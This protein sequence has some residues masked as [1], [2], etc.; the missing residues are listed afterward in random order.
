MAWLFSRRRRYDELSDSIREHLEEKIADLTDRGMTRKQA[1][2]AARREFGNVTLI[3][4]RSREVWQWPAIEVMLPDLKLAFRRLRKSPGFTTTALLLLAIGIGASTAIFTVIDGV[5]LRPLP[6]PHSEQLVALRHTAPGINIPDLNMATSLYLTYSEESRVFQ[7]VAMWTPDSWTATSADR[8]EQ[9]PGLSVTHDFLA[10]LGVQPQLGRGFTMADETPDS[11]RTVMVSDSYWK[12]RLGGARDVV[13]RRILLNSNAYTVIGVLPPSFEFMD[14]KI[15]LVAPIRFKRS[16]VRLI[17]FCCDGIAR[18]KPAGTL[19]QA[20]ADVARMLPIAARKF[21]MNPGW[22]PTAFADA[23]IA[24]RLRLLK[25]TLV[26]DIGKMLWVLMGTVSIVLLIA[27]ANVANLFLVRADGRR[28][29]LAIRAAL[30]AKMGRLVRELLLE[31][32]LLG[33]AGGALGMAFAYFALRLLVSSDMTNLPRV[34]GI[35]MHP[36][37]FV[38]TSSVSLLAGLLLGLIPAIQYGHPKVSIS[39]RGEGRSLT[40][41]KERQRT[42]SFLIT[43]QVALALI[44]LVGSGLMI[45]TFRALHHV[46]PGFSNAEQL[47]TLNIGIPDTQIKDPEQ[48]VR[49]EEA[50]VRNI[51]AISGVSQVAAISDLPLAGGE[52]DPIYAEDHQGRDSSLPSVRR[53][54]YVSPGYF[55]T[56]DSR[57]V[58]GRDLTWSEVYNRTPV[59]L[60]SENLARELWGDPRAAMG[61]RVRVKQKDY[62]REVIGV[63]ADL[64]DDGIDQKAPAIVYWPLLLKY[65]DENDNV[66]RSPMFIARTPRAGSIALR[67]DIQRAVAGVNASLAISEVSTLQSVYDRSL[68]RSSVVLALLAIAGAMSLLLGVVGIYAVISYSVSQRRREIGIRLAL[69]AQKPA[70]QWMFVRSALALTSVGIAVG[71]IAAFSLVPLMKA[72]LFGVRPFDV[73][74]FIAVPF[75]LA[76][77]TVLASYLPARRAASVDPSQTLRSE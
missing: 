68:A 39:L 72:L 50:I 10:T 8:P 32:M 18:L 2:R 43:V 38:F 28:Q 64:H 77:A 14:G 53:F 51:E 34:H 52:N 11:E 23:R 9:V 37:A 67:E 60:V 27:C 20:N 3:E 61:K 25:D 73:R 59:V 76:V 19:A 62:W 30:G 71:L 69:G 33:M 56:V 49:T 31:S 24:P 58:A 15:S 63:V 22:S 4:Q 54:K 75:I 42:R 70:L 45:Q 44:L 29:E 16:D 21:P 12:T 13:G 40:A 48:V 1:E 57:L 6:Y 7:S 74:T 46:D 66:I 36:L 47:E 35:S 17:G 26:G 5:L 65:E 41:H 55:S